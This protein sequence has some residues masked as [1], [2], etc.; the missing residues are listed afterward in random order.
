MTRFKHSVIVQ[1]RRLDGVGL[2][3]VLISLLVLSLGMLGLAGLQMWSLKTNE[4][5][6]ERG[7]AVMQTHSIVDAMRV[8]RANA[9]AG[10]FN[11]DG[12]TGA[13]LPSDTTFAAKAVTAWVGNL[14]NRWGNRATGFIN[15]GA[16]GA[17]SVGVTWDEQRAALERAQAPSGR[18]QPVML[19]IVTEVLL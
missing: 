5:S 14:K 13:S 9:L 11:Y 6:L 10:R 8:D 7:L 18:D 4:S 16:S 19:E 12:R 2:I 1:R 15:C 3:E 17:C